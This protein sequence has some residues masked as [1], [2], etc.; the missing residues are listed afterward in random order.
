LPPRAVTV[1]RVRYRIFQADVGQ[2]LLVARKAARGLWSP[3][4]AATLHNYEH[5]VWPKN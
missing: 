2:L 5:L 1:Q 3:L 4:I